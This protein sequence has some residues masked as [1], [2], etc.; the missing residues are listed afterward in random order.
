MS[1]PR[2]SIWAAAPEPGIPESPALIADSDS[3]WLAY[4]RAADEGVAVIQFRGVIDHHLS[5]IND[6]GLGRHPY[7]GAGL[8]FYGFNEVVG[9]AEADRWSSLGARHWVV[10]FKDNTL[11]VVAR[12]AEVLVSSMAA[13]TPLAALLAT[14]KCV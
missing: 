12:S 5:P 11:D 2:A 1:K 3:L 10:T 4:C 7:A 8:E 9:S 13:A 14:V 6:E